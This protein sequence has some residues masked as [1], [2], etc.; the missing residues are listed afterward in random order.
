M[1]EDSFSIR[2][3]MHLLKSRHSCRHCQKIII[4]PENS[5]TPVIRKS[6]AIKF[7]NTFDLT[8]GEIAQADQDGRLLFRRLISSMDFPASNN[9]LRN[10]AHAERVVLLDLKFNSRPSQKPPS[11]DEVPVNLMSA[12]VEWRWSPHTESPMSFDPQAKNEYRF[13]AEAGMIDD[14]SE[15]V[16]LFNM[17]I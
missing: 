5:S 2:I 7:K 3:S 15:H 17:I 13:D 16:L 1:V 8:A 10:N 12:R 14:L 4:D 6:S 9:P 11:P